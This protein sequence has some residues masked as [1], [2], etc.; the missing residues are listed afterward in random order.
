MRRMI[1]NDDGRLGLDKRLM[2]NNCR[3]I[4]DLLIV[5]YSRLLNNHVSPTDNILLYISALGIFFGIQLQL[6][7]FNAIQISSRA[8]GISR[9]E[10]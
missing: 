2:L 5:K 10:G 6:I 1:E 7:L 4:T 8:L 9:A 3:I